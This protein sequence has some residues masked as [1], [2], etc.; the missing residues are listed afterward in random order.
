MPVTR[1]QVERF[2]DAVAEGNVDDVRRMLSAGF[3]V[4]H[5]FEVITTALYTLRIA[6]TNCGC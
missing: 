4:D 5:A 2:R 1:G 3:D 6:S